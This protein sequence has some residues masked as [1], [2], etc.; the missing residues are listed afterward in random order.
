[1]QAPQVKMRDLIVERPQKLASRPSPDFI[2]RRS[3]SENGS[4]AEIAAALCQHVD[5]VLSLMAVKTMQ[6][7]C[8]A[9]QAT[10]VLDKALVP[11]YFGCGHQ[12]PLL[13][14]SKAMPESPSARQERRPRPPLG[15]M[16]ANNVAHTPRTHL[17]DIGRKGLPAFAGVPLAMDN[18]EDI[19]DESETCTH[20]TPRTSATSRKIFTFKVVFSRTVKQLILVSS[21]H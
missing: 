15:H 5:D 11:N 13:T 21:S 16:Y 7:E 14:S 12:L 4:D 2:E 3:L 19:G 1:M 17:M 20:S 10:L 6:E 18:D 9:S 8:D